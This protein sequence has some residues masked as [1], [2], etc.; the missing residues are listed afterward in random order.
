MCESLIDLT[1]A[2][3]S[4]TEALAAG[5]AVAARACGISER[6]GRLAAGLDADLLAVEGNLATGI[7]ALRDV[8]M[9][10]SRGRTVIAPPPAGP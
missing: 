8:R 9:V 6:T 4:S 2:G 7:A 3:L 10:V 1:S 5:T